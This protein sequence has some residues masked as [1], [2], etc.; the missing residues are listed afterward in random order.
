MVVWD[1]RTVNTGPSLDRAAWSRRAVDTTLTQIHALATEGCRNCRRSPSGPR[2]R[3]NGRNANSRA[4]RRDRPG[5]ARCGLAA[6]LSPFR[7]RC[8]GSD[9]GR[10]GPDGRCHHP[11]H[12][13]PARRRRR[14]TPP[15][16]R[17]VPHRPGHAA[18]SRDRHH[19]LRHVAVGTLDKTVSR[20]FP[21]LLLW[22][23]LPERYWPNSTTNGRSPTAATCPSPPW[24]S[25]SA[26]KPRPCSPAGR[27]CH[28]AGRPP[29]QRSV[30]PRQRTPSRC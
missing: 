24:P 1:V 18:R 6:M 29:E 10:F 7:A 30:T 25:C 5:L 28:E 16:R 8:A 11:H 19:R 13:R 20:S 23:V 17:P 15:A 26:P 27:H 2:R 14:R 4:G 12:L 21:T 9:R 3:T 22:S